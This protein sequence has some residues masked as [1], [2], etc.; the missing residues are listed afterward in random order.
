MKNAL[1]KID[2]HFPQ[3]FFIN[4]AH[5][6]CFPFGMFG[7]NNFKRFFEILSLLVDMAVES[8]VCSTLL[9]GGLLVFQCVPF[10]NGST[11]VHSFDAIYYLI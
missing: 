9:F 3:L 11:A 2:L 6:F 7:Y 4:F 1:K 10:V 8:E 5:Y